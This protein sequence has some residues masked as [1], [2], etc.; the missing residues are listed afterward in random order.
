MTG[1]KK[2]YVSTSFWDDPWIQSLD[3]SQKFLYLYLI[4]NPL[5][6]IAG[7]YEV[8]M[9]RIC[10]DTGYNED[11]VRG[12]MAV[13]AEADKAHYR[14]GWICIPR[15]TRHQKI[16]P[17]NNVRKGIDRILL[18]LPDAVWRWSIDCGYEYAYL[19]NI[20]SSRRDLK[21]LLNSDSDS[22]LDNNSDSDVSLKG[23]REAVGIE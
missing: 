10:F 6:N 3:P 13:F 15:F 21:G 4:T 20:H 16:A 17:E 8:T 22:D 5:T 7:I 19:Q 1:S 14:D 18:D 12:I 2:R 11:T 9:R 23:L